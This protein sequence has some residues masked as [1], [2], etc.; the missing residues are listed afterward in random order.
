[1]PESVPM[2]WPVR[3][4][5]RQPVQPNISELRET[6]RAILPR[7]PPGP[8]SLPSMG[9][10]ARPRTAVYAALVC[11]AG[12]I[13][14]GVVAELVPAAHVRDSASLQGFAALRDTTFSH[15][16]ERIAHLADGTP[17]TLFAAAL[18]LVAL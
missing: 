11:L 14:T 15:S 8:R 17:Y 6:G 10:F 5:T 1:M 2:R 4:S 16:L 12:L 13:V 7:S 3:S 18:V 9:M